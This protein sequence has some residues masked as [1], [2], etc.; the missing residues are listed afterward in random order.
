MYNLKNWIYSSIFKD[1]SQSDYR[2]SITLSSLPSL[3]FYKSRLSFNSYIIAKVSLASSITASLISSLAQLNKKSISFLK[4]KLFLLKSF[5]LLN[6]VLKDLISEPRIMQIMLGFS[7]NCF[8]FGQEEK[9]LFKYI[10]LFY[11][12]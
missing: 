4:H 10:N 3:F 2:S 11:F 8:R 9:P 12:K 6:L 1:G 5:A 7:S